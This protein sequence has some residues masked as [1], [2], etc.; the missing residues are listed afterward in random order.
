MNHRI[1]RLNELVKEE[2]GKMFLKELDFENVL[3]TIMTVEIS[4]DL[5]DARI[6]V[7]VMPLTKFNEV[8]EI[9]RQNRNHLRFLLMKR[10]K[11]RQIPQ[12][13]FEINEQ[14]EK[15]SEVEKIFSND[16]IE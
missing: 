13:N 14:P 1:E 11:I 5:V 9:L 8:A 16:K 12:L 3:V 2:L 15:A 6:K 10:I 7:N 4:D